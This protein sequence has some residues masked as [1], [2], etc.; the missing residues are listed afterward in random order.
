MVSHRAFNGIMQT[1]K[2]EVHFF[3]FSV[4]YIVLNCSWQLIMFDKKQKKCVKRIHLVTDDD[5]YDRKAFYKVK[6]VF[7]QPLNKCLRKTLKIK[8][9]EYNNIKI[10]QFLTKLAYTWENVHIANLPN[11]PAETQ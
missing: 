2:K 3:F 10:L 11:R 6:I 4:C 5:L 1:P 8:N 7:I 9:Y